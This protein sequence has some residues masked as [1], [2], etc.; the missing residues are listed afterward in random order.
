MRWGFL[1]ALAACGGS[2]GGGAGGGLPPGAQAIPAEPQRAGNPDAGYRALINADYIGCGVPRA[3]YTRVFGGSWPQRFLLPGRDPASADLPYFLTAVTGDDGVERV[4]A[5]CLSCHASFL[6]DEL[7]IGLGDAS[8]DFSI[9][10]RMPLKMAGLIPMSDAERAQLARFRERVDAVAPYLYTD[11]LGA[12]P[13]DAIA[14]ALFAHRD[15]KTLAWSAEPLIPLPEPRVVPVD[16]PPWWRMRR[17]HAMFYTA[18]G[19]GDHA[20]IMM[21]ASAL[22][23]DSVDR[24]RRIDAL[25]PDIRAYIASLAPPRWKSPIDRPL[26]ARGRQ[27]FA[28][29]CARCHGEGD[30]YPNL[31]IP[32]RVVGTDP[33]LADG[34]GQFGRPF[35]DWFNGSF[36]GE[37]ARLEPAAGYVAPPLDGIWATGPFLHNGAVPTLAALLDSKT[38]PRYWSRTGGLDAEAVGVRHTVLPRGKPAPP[39]GDIRVVDTTRPGYSAAGHTFGDRL[40]PADR[41]ALLEHLKT[42]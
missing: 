23:T 31:V 7:V 1:L 8:L 27:V 40:T 17:K 18:A 35:V 24:A 11:T 28:A 14:G 33:L 29:T 16:V 41:R 6:G 10:P 36:Y 15:R 4:T 25:F 9:D 20:R 21:T 32:L 22:C 30:R 2:A 13:G 5:N 38:R 42:L 34:A 39:D 26:A 12:N 37:V 19:R 3:V